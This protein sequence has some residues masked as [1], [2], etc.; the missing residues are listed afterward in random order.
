MGLIRII[1]S[2]FGKS[3]QEENIPADASPGSYEMEQTDCRR[4]G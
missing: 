4:S 2:P 1:Q 3:R